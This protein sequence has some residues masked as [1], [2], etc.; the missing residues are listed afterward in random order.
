MSEITASASTRN[1]SIR[2][3]ASEV[4][5]PKSIHVDQDELR[6]GGTA[7]AATVLDLCLR[8]TQRARA[9]RRTVLENEGMDA[10]TLDRLGFP[11]AAVVATQ[12]NERMDDEVAPSSWMRSV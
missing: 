12:E 11:S 2:V 4:G 3:L 1:E 6:F 9:Q 7:L 5:L 8:A 10:E